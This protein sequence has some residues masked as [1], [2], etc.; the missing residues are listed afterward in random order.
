MHPVL[1]ALISRPAGARLVVAIEGGG[2]RGA[3]SGGMVLAL[4]ELGF[5]GAFAAAYGSS[6][7][8]LNALWLAS[9]RAGAGIETWTDA[10]WL[11]FLI[12]R[13]RMLTG[14]P[15]VDVNGLVRQRYEALC[16]DLFTAMLAS[17]TE[18]HPLATDVATGEPLDLHPFVHDVESLRTALCATSMIPLLAGP[19]VVLGG[20]RLLDAGLSAAIPIRDA[21]AGGATHVLLLRSRRLGEMTEAPHGLGARVTS[22]LLA[23]ID[24]Q[25]ARAFHVRAAGELE[26][27]ALIARHVADPALRPHILEVRPA[28]GSPVPS[29]LERDHAVVRGGFEAGYAAARAALTAVG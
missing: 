18:L 28:P 12:R 19:P 10:E 27:E 16:P 26:D 13:R 1:A 2:M 8:A 24:P 25:V 20:H 29:R 15:A 17:T 4:H 3:V 14:G 7:G 22:R 21:L 23:R 11:A 6:A 5:D 9:G